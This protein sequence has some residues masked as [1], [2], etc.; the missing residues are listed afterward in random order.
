MPVLDLGTALCEDLGSLFSLLK[1]AELRV[2][3]DKDDVALSINLM[4]RLMI[5]LIVVRMMI[6]SQ[7]ERRNQRREAHNHELLVASS[8]FLHHDDTMNS[9]PSVI[10]W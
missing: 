6:H 3:I 8:T 2:P 1:D 10:L 4:I 7:I 9:N 5:W